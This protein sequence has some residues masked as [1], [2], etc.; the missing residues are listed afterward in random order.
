MSEKIAIKIAIL[1]LSALLGVAKIK[2]LS[3][4]LKIVWSNSRAKEQYGASR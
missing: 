3:I 2:R 1:V 4:V